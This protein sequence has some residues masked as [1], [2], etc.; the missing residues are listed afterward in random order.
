MRT[1]TH[2]LVALNLPNTVAGLSAYAKHVVQSMTGNAA[3]PSPTPPLATVTA[4]IAALDAAETTVKTRAPGSAEARNLKLQV[5]VN[6]MHGL[7]ACVQTAADASPA[8]AAAIIESAGMHVKPHGVHAKPD[9]EALM[10]PGGLVVLR[11]RAAGKTA[12]YEWQYSL[13]GGKTWIPS[14]VTTEANT[15]IA[16]LTVGTTYLFRVRS[17]VGHNVGDWS[18]SVSLVVH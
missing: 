1:A 15:S 18:Q 14:G 11:A 2:T 17:T 16:R 4:D 13:D 6:D 12:A 10:G 9:L 7:E 3:I 5:V 8:E